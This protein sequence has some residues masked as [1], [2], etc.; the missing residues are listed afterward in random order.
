M[1]KDKKPARFWLLLQVSLNLHKVEK[2][3][4]IF[5]VS[6]IT[7]VLVQYFADLIFTI[8]S[9]IVSYSAHSVI[10][11]YKLYFSY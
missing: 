9:K 4:C 3:L 2:K 7:I 8:S 11:I 10:F 1:Q 6:E 5:S